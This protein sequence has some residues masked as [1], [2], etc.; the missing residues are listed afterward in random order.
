MAVKKRVSTE[1]TDP[2]L[3]A[4]L[5]NITEDKITSS[6]IFGLFG[7]YDGKCKCHPYDILKVPPGYYGPENHKNK[8]T[9]TTTVGIWIF[10]KWFIEQDLFELFGYINNGGSF[11]YDEANKK[12]IYEKAS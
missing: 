5:L 2:T 6:F 1:V 8:N 3:K 10:N 7:E 12:K 9:F 4:E 11:Y